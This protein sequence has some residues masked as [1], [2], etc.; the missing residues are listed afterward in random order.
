[1]S[2]KNNCLRRD[3]DQSINLPI[4][5]LLMLKITKEIFIE[6]GFCSLKLERLKTHDIKDDYNC[7]NSLCHNIVNRD[8]SIFNSVSCV[9]HNL[10]SCSHVIKHIF[11]EIKIILF[12][13]SKIILRHYKYLENLFPKGKMYEKNP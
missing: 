6:V 5:K 12:V 2:N 7:S 1:M 8:S 4:I 13:N 10:L 3:Y 9:Y 11:L